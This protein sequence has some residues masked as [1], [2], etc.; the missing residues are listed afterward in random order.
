MF[1]LHSEIE[2]NGS[3]HS[4][5]SSYGLPTPV[6]P[7]TSPICV[8]LRLAG[9]TALIFST[10]CAIYL[11]WEYPTCA[12]LVSPSVIPMRV[13]YVY[14]SLVVPLFIFRPMVPEHMCVFCCSAPHTSNYCYCSYIQSFCHGV[15]ASK[16]SVCAAAIA[17]SIAVGTWFAKQRRDDKPHSEMNNYIFLCKRLYRL[18]VSNCG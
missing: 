14:S 16:R 3:W 6:V 4:R 10:F 17:N 18:G 12:I 1:H 2:R 9:H 5:L 7:S 15:A 8:D 11:S 13:Q